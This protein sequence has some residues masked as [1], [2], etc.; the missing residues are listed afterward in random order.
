[1]AADQA[2]QAVEWLQLFTC[3]GR[4]RWKWEGVGGNGAV[5]WDGFSCLTCASLNSSVLRKQAVGAEQAVDGMT[6]M[7]ARP[8]CL[9]RLRRATHLVIDTK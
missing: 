9:A 3:R 1:M 8:S 7:L 2:V 4:G 5:R 6:R